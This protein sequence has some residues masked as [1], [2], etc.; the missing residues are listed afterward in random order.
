MLVE[1]KSPEIFCAGCIGRAA[2][3]RGKRSDVPNV[4]LLRMRP[5]TPKLHILQHPL[6]Q[7]TDRSRSNHSVHREF[8]C[9]QG[10]SQSHGDSASPK[11][12]QLRR[13]PTP[14][15]PPA[16]RVRPSP[17]TGRSL[18]AVAHRSGWVRSATANVCSLTEVADVRA[19]R[20]E[21]AAYPGRGKLVAGN[22]NLPFVG[23]IL[24]DA[25]R[26]A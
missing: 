26:P 1:L 20:Q 15:A 9:V 12:S 6:P 8:L 4:V 23:A 22:L 11:A 19:D 18:P 16:E 7:R 21:G 24:G 5:K 25:T 17:T 14:S 10:T 13:D 3:K 2:Q